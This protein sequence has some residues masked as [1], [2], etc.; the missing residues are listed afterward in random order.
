[1]IRDAAPRPRRRVFRRRSTHAL[2]CAAP[3][4][5]P[6][7]IA[8][9]RLPDGGGAR[10]CRPRPHLRDG[11]VEVEATFPIG[12]PLR[13]VRPPLP[14]IASNIGQTQ[15]SSGATTSATRPG[16]GVIEM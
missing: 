1:M 7:A 12:L 6:A 8:V 5:E 10:R 9:L 14:A 4:A 2:R 13:A 15:V 11:D 16:C 3:S